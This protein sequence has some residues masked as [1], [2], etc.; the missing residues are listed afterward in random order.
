MSDPN[1]PGDVPPDLPPEYAEAY[2]RGYERAFQQASA[3]VDDPAPAAPRGGAH[4]AEPVAPAPAPLDDHFSDAEPYEPRDR[5]AWLVPALLAAL[6]VVLLL[7]AYGIGRVALRQPR[8]RR[9]RAGPAGRRGDR[10]GRGDELA[11]LDGPS[12]KPSKKPAG[13]KYA[14]PTSSATI[15]GASATCEAATGRR[16]RRATR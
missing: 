10:R 13:K 4:R 12:T 14:G 6:V 11:R 16:L 9:C 15:G 1:R 5:P 2:R 8:G 3:E 7:G